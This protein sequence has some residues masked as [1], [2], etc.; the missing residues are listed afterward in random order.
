MSGSEPPPPPPGDGSLPEG[1]AIVRPRSGMGL[2]TGR[3]AL[4]AWRVAVRFVI[5]LCLLLVIGALFMARWIQQDPDYFVQRLLAIQGIEVSV[6]KATWTPEG[7]LLLRKVRLGPEEDLWMIVSQVV[8]E[9]GWADLL[10]LRT[11]DRVDL[12]YPQL[13]MARFERAMERAGVL[14]NVHIAKARVFAGTIMLDEIAPD[15]QPI[16]IQLGQ[17]KPL[18]VAGFQLGQWKHSPVLDIVQ[19]AQVNDLIISSPYDALSQ[20]LA[21]GKISITFTW[22]ELL[23]NH[24]RRVVL[25]KPI[26]YLGPDL[27]WFVDELKKNAAGTAAGKSWTLGEFIAREGRLGVNV[28]GAGGI[29]LPPPFFCEAK[30]LD[31]GDTNRSRINTLFKFKKEDY[32]YPEYGLEVLGLRGRIEFALPLDAEKADNVVPTLFADSI[33]W[34]GVAVTEPW[35]SVTFDEKGIYG[36]LGGK[37]Y[38]GDISSNFDILFDGG[39]PWSGDFFIIKTDMEPIVKDLISKYLELKGYANGDLHVKGESTKLI[40]ARANFELLERGVFNVKFIADLENRIPKDWLPL[41]KQLAQIAID[42]FKTYDFTGGKVSA[43]YVPGISTGSLLLNGIQGKRTI[44]V[45]VTEEDVVNA[46]KKS[47]Y[48]R[49]EALREQM[50][51]TN[52]EVAKKEKEE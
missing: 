49:R 32:R 46:E 38:E 30:D 11:V 37:F 15:I 9:F 16:P 1:R 13:W 39:F 31:L 21:F 51:E 26:I 47:L 7:E 4:T 35:T 50:Q 44:H 8:V 6:G 36:K 2:R 43:T 33:S 17:K 28:F 42:A 45:K 34:Q 10:L 29:V 23:Q 52:A 41:Y 22:E 12:K 18:V 5:V 3:L 24:I 14:P 48:E 20:V 27:F 25:D 40:E 19:T